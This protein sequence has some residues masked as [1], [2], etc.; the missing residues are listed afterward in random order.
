MSF[1][2]LFCLSRSG[3]FVCDAFEPRA[4][5]KL[6]FVGNGGRFRGGEND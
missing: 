5:V 2:G 6:L 4:E 1:S 3:S